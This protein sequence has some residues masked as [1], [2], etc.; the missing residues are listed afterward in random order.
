MIFRLDS[1]R[2]LFPECFIRG[3]QSKHRRYDLTPKDSKLPGVAGGDKVKLT[4]NNSIEDV[5]QVFAQAIDIESCAHL[6]LRMLFRGF[7]ARTL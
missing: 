2:S 3:L 4:E 6:V 1:S 7:F 5:K